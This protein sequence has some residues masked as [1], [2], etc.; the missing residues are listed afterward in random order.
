MPEFNQ[1][2]D[3][4][5]ELKS[6]KI[7]YDDEIAGIKKS[8]EER[9]N[10]ESSSECFY[11]GKL[12]KE[13]RGNYGSYYMCRCSPEYLGDNCQVRKSL[14][15]SV[16]VKLMHALDGIEKRIVNSNLHE[17][18]KLIT[19]LILVNKFRLS[20]LIIERQ[21]QIIQLF[22]EKDK[23]LDNRKKLY[24]LYDAIILNL[25]DSL[26]DMKKATFE[27]YNTDYKIQSERDEVYSLIHKVIS[28]LESSLEDH[29]YLNSFLEKK[30][31]NYV[32]LDT[33]SYV[34]GEHRLKNFDD[35]KGFTIHNPNIDSSFNTRQNNRL[36]LVFD[37]ADSYK[38]SKNN[39]QIITF[40][41]PLFNDK[42]SLTDDIPV[43][44]VLYAKYIRPK[45]P[46]ETVLHREN[47]VRKLKIDFALVFT[48]AYEDILSN[49]S[50]MAYYF[51]KDKFNI[52]GDAISLDE[53]TMVV[54]CEFP[55]YFEF[56]NYYFAVS[57][58][59]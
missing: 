37:T 53:D 46:Q 36:H 11:N 29:V 59:K 16:Q 52:K 6:L 3:T 30:S 22:L 45:T 17:K 33:Y 48:P 26:E 57:M 42:L 15:D 44:N 32:S 47:N 35:T 10:A 28:M 50:C 58:K 5:Q 1:S 23:D 31:P 25:F 40:A 4:L 27:I 43:S 14:Y 34:I 38:N 9:K 39:M 54:T 2:K 41:A 12:N 49:V 7:K 20:R 19:A 13:I 51:G 21:V 24:V 8:A 55:T 56:K 18:K